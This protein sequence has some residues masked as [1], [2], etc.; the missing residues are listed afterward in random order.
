MVAA[1][2]P[3]L[4]RL[5]V[6]GRYCPGHVAGTRRWLP[7]APVLIVCSFPAASRVRNGRSLL[8]GCLCMLTLALVLLGCGS[9]LLQGNQRMLEEGFAPTG[10]SSVESLSGD[11]PR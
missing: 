11:A 2:R 3:R 10:A 1:G 4:G 8:C 9:G 6:L 5:A 7:P